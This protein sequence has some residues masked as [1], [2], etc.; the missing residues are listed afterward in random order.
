VG[1]NGSL[2]R[3]KKV[4][5]QPN[6]KNMNVNPKKLF[7]VSTPI[8]ILLVTQMTAVILGSFLSNMVFIPIFLIYWGLLALFLSLYGLGSIRE[9]LHKPLGHWVWIVLAV[10]LG[11]TSL[12]LFISNVHL[13]RNIPVLLLH[14]TFFVINPWLEEFYWRGLLIDITNKWPVWLSASYSSILFTLWHS[15]F[16]WYSESF[17]SVSF[18]APVL[19][20]GF[21]MVLIYKKTKSLWLCIFS[22]MLINIFNMGIPV[23]MNMIQV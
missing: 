23:L 4:D 6:E 22:H 19:I 11:F 7:F 9:W 1:L 15:A 18:Y 2:L 20:M 10:M 8:I 17:R 14:L 21:A 3:L 12:P 16:S 13:F 5:Q